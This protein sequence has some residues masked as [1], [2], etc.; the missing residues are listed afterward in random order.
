YRGIAPAR[1]GGFWLANYSGAPERL[2]ADGTVERLPDTVAAA[3]GGAKLSTIA[4]TVDGTLWM[5][6]RD[7]VFQ[8]AD[9]KIR[10]W[11]T[12]TAVDPLLPGLDLMRIAPDGSL[13]LSCNGTGLQQRDP[14]SGRVL[15]TWKAGT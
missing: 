10:S 5:G 12:S 13:W 15:R 14:A 6:T 1:D 11:N 8:F 9:G 3:V 7:A 4:E 2:A